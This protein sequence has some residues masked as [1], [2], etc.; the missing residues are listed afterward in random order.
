[1]NEKT[2]RKSYRFLAVLVLLL[3]ILLSPFAVKWQKEGGRYEASAST[4][5]SSDGFSVDNYIVD[6]TVQTNRKVKVRESI[7]ITFLRSGLT[8]FYRSLPTTGGMY[9]DIKATCPGNDAFRYDVIDSPD[10]HGFIDV[11][12]IGNAYNGASWTYEIT[13]TMQTDVFKG[14]GMKIDVVGFGFPVPLHNVTATV[15]FP[16]AVTDHEVYIG[17]YGVSAASPNQY[18][19]SADGRTLTVQKDELPVRYNGTYDEYMAE[20]IT[21]DFTLPQGT[22]AS[23]AKSRVFTAEMGI[24]LLIAFLLIGGAAV[25][26]MLRD[27]RDIV[28]TVHLTPP[29]GMTPMQMGTL[30]DGQVDNEDSTSML[31][32]FADKGYLQIDFSNEDDPKLIRLAPELPLSEPAHARTLYKSLFEGGKRDASGL[33]TTYVSAIGGNFFQAIQ[34]AKKQVPTPKP[35]YTK[36]SV[37]SFLSGG[38][39][40]GLFG[41]FGAFAMG[42]AVG[43]G[44]SY[45]LG[46]IFL[47]PVIVNLLLGWVRENYR[48]KWKGGKRTAVYVLEIVISVAMTL[49]FVFLFAKHTMTE[50]EK[51]ALCLGA[52]IP[53]L[54]TEGA[55]TRSET[56]QTTLGDVLGFKD[57]ITYTEEDKIKFMLEENPQLYYQILPYAQVLGVTDEWEKKF[58]RLALEPP[59]W[60]VGRSATVYDYLLI[61]RCM[62]RSMLAAMAAAARAAGDSAGR[63]GGG[64]G[65][66]GFGGG[67]FGGG[68]GGVR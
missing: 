15:H 68:G 62:R 37:L 30:L 22:L 38:I 56:Y 17:A 55:L 2:K 59:N 31:Y 6:M 3:A 9:E 43:G 52:L 64:G 14:D 25:I 34:T 24:L 42:K 47:L 32:Y 23:Y 58:E 63:S 12:C 5:Y 39:L 11:E 50:W 4:T 26:F 19:L 13:Y 21:V 20:G 66:G 53:P 1:M 36:K 67:G 65:F 49:L 45:I 57:F 54:I 8:M 33:V 10:M 35:M 41:F 18:K 51:L 16:A 44:Y 46:I 61:D 7:S 48:Y 29:N 27:K 40:G 60:Y 28:T